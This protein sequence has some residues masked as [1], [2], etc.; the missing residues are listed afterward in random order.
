MNIKFDYDSEINM[1]VIRK[2]NEIVGAFKQRKDAEAALFNM[3]KNGE[4][5]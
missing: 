2:E 3:Y 5:Q 1:W 4:I